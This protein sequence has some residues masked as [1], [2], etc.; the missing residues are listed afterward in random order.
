MISF[1][2]VVGDDEASSAWVDKLKQ[3]LITA[4]TKLA[5]DAED[6]AIG[7]LGTQGITREGA[8]CVDI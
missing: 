2:G 5:Q 1:V 6:R 7:E 4:M 3:D 8:W